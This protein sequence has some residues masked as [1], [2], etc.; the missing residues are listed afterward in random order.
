MMEEC[1]ADNDDLILKSNG[2]SREPGTHAKYVD[3]TVAQLPD[4]GW[5]L[6]ASGGP[7]PLREKTGT[8]VNYTDGDGSDGC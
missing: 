4:G 5:R 7:N 8:C 2:A 1:V 3:P 6:M